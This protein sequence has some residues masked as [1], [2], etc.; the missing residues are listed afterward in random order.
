MGSTLLVGLTLYLMPQ[1]AGGNTDDDFDAARVRARFHVSAVPPVVLRALGSVDPVVLSRRQRQLEEEAKKEERKVVEAR[2]R[3]LT[4]RAKRDAL[5]EG[6]D[7][8][9]T[10]AERAAVKTELESALREFELSC[11]RAKRARSKL[12]VFI[13]NRHELELYLKNSTSHKRNAEGGS[14]NK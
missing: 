13:G 4:V 5:W 10:A 8:E 6:A 7:G 11:D 14:T 12:E 9:A 2:D 3:V 1:W